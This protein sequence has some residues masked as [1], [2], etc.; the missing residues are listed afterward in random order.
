MVD[1]PEKLLECGRTVEICAH[2]IGDRRTRVTDF[3]SSDSLF[4][5]RPLE[6]LFDS[7]AA[8]IK[9]LRTIDKHAPIVELVHQCFNEECDVIAHK[10]SVIFDDESRLRPHS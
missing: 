8:V 1:V 5:W 2:G 10:L 3:N 6:N 7:E 4:H 9:G